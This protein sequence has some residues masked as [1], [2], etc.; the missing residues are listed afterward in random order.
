M[1]IVSV[2]EYKAHQDSTKKG[3]KFM[4]IQEKRALSVLFQDHKQLKLTI[5]KILS[6]RKA[7]IKKKNAK[8][9]QTR[10]QNLAEMVFWGIG[11][12]KDEE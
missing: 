3:W 4:K 1:F 6:G 5:N 12:E 10:L 9:E 2:D 7:K 8:E 11:K